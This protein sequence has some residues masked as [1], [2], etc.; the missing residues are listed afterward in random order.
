MV[1]KVQNKETGDLYA[2]KTILKSKVPDLALLE[3]EVSI[4][5]TLHHHPH[6]I[7]LFEV[8]DE[9]TQLHLI[10]ELCTGGE[11]YDKVVEK[12][13]KGEHFS[14]YDAGRIIRNIL[15]AIAYCHAHGICH[16]DLK[17]ENFLLLTPDNDSPV[18][19]IDFGL[20]RSM[21]SVVYDGCLDDGTGGGESWDAMTS[22]V[23]TVYYVAPEVM[24]QATYTQ[25]CDIWSIGVIVYVLLCGFPPFYAPSEAETL[26]LVVNAEVEFPSPSW[27]DVSMEA[28]LFILTLLDR[29]VD[30][31]PA[32]TE[33]LK[34]PWLHH[35]LVQPAGLPRQAS[36]RSDD[37]DD[38]KQQEPSASHSSTFGEVRPSQHHLVNLSPI[39]NNASSSSSFTKS[40]PQRLGFHR[41]L[42]RI[43]LMKRQQAR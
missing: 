2:L 28:K 38:Q 11:L 40:S 21:L 30:T 17:V 16:R 33:A 15:E 3:R 23:G 14:E 5:Q 9:P 7:Q 34:H 13:L 10:T 26:K 43:K 20:S 29:N 18:K 12:T 37:V 39:D 36:F 4:L 8:F 1:R 41:F 31:R 22:R 35:S 27:D 19:I 24:T 32:A 6:I 25:N 42:Q